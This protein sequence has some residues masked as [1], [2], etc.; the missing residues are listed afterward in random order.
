MQSCSTTVKCRE[1]S[2][3]NNDLQNGLVLKRNTTVPLKLFWKT[4]K[5]C[6]MK[7]KNLSYFMDTQLKMLSLRQNKLFWYLFSSEQINWW[8]TENFYIVFG[9]VCLC[10]FGSQSSSMSL[11]FF[12]ESVLFYNICLSFIGVVFWAGVCIFHYGIE[13]QPSHC[14]LEWKGVKRCP[15]ALQQVMLFH[16]PQ[17]MLA[18]RE[19]RGQNFPFNSRQ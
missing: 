6:F 10:S 7:H 15:L 3:N 2:I 17:E 19:E 14:L 1:K 16:V 8:E 9:N 11:P 13:I 5:D 18:C 12:T 4:R